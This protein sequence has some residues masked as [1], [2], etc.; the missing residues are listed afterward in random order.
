MHKHVF[1]LLKIIFSKVFRLDLNKRFILILK[2][3]FCIFI[4]KEI[5]NKGEEL[6]GIKIDQCRSEGKV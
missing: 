3:D 4:T 1:H 2:P 6:L 5:L